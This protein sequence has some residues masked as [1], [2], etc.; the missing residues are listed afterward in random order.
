MDAI[1]RVTPKTTA[2][3]IDVRLQRGCPGDS[4]PV[5]GDLVKVGRGRSQ[6]VSM[7]QPSS[8]V[9]AVLSGRSLFRV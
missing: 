4:C 7:V 2:S 6:P 8:T 5:D 3:D 1:Q 9:D